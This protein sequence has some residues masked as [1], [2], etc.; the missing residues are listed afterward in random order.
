M[1]AHLAPSDDMQKVFTAPLASTARGR[2]TRRKGWWAAYLY[3][4][5]GLIFLL[6]FSLWPIFESLYQSLFRIN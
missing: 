2:V 1:A 4:L 3:L 6:A 5:P